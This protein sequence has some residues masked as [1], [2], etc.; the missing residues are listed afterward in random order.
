MRCGAAELCTRFYPGRLALL[1]LFCPLVRI[2]RVHYPSFSNAAL[3]ARLRELAARERT[4]TADFVACLAE[5]DRRADVIFGEGYSSPFDFCVR[6]LKLA[7]ST[8][9]QRVRAARLARARPE[10]LSLLADGSVNVSILCLIAPWLEKH[11]DLLEKVAGKS[12]REVEADIAALGGAREVPDRIRPLAPRPPPLIEDEPL[13]LLEPSR[14]E[15]SSAKTSASD[16]PPPENSPIERR[17]EFRF[18]AGQ[19]FVQ[20]VERLRAM[21]WHKFPAGRLEDVLFEAARDFIARRDPARERKRM[22]S[23]GFREARRSRRVPAALRRVVWRRD[24]GRCAF[25]GPAGRCGESRG[26]EI[27]HVLPW[28]QGGRSDESSN[29]RLLCRAHN[30]SE[31]RRVFGNA[32]LPG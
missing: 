31:A 10:I 5:A 18:A 19:P 20:A 17:M 32:S 11:P 9:Y 25:S 2:P 6:D 15:S 23:G 16:L 12:K 27:D 1:E 8:A 21:L 29:L 3:L 22:L 14:C 13:P 30:Q 24:G 28:A 26:L 4:A 7:E